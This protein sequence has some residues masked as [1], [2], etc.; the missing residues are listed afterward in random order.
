MGGMGGLGGMGGMQGIGG[1]QSMGM[2]PMGGGM[3]GGMG[4]MGMEG[5]M[6]GMASMEG[7]WTIQFRTQRWYKFSYEVEMK[8]N[9][10]VDLK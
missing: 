9:E 8:G 1:M 4:S 2:E 6:G 7:K 5:P 10:D 3:G